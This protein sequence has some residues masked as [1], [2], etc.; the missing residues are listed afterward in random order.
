M[1]LD[2]ENDACASHEE[3]GNPTSTDA[4]AS[5][6][7]CANGKSDGIHGS[8]WSR[9]NPWNRGNYATL[10]WN[11]ESLES[12]STLNDYGHH[13]VHHFGVYLGLHEAYE[14]WRA[15]GLEPLGLNDSGWSG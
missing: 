12:P 15:S 4:S 9:E 11:G 2:A 13:G 1:R 10:V 7:A 3:C 5:H 6:S 8:L 14:A